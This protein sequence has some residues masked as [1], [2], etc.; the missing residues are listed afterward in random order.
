MERLKVAFYVL[1]DAH[2][3]LGQR[4]LQMLP[5]AN[6]SDAT[7]AR[8]AYMIATSDHDVTVVVTD[9]TNTSYSEAETQLDSATGSA[10]V[11]YG[12]QYGKE[13][14]SPEVAQQFYHAIIAEHADEMFSTTVAIA[15][16]EELVAAIQVATSTGERQAYEHAYNLLSEQ[17]SYEYSLDGTEDGTHLRRPDRAVPL[18][19][20]LVELAQKADG[21]DTRKVHYLLALRQYSE[22]RNQR[23]MTREAL[24]AASEVIKELDVPG[25][26]AAFVEQFVQS[27]IARLEAALGIHK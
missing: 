7:H 13:W 15:Q 25:Q 21:G 4:G 9:S 3:Q 23:G 18:F 6:Y 26:D 5:L 16:R 22:Y 2:Y 11:W 1:A 12:Q 8:D 19:E 14:L 20:L 27:E 17:L 10:A 24:R